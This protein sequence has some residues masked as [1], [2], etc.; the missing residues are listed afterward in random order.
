MDNEFIKLERD[1][2]IGIMYLNNGQKNY[3]PDPDFIDPLVIQNWVYD[4]KIKG[5][6]ITGMGKHFSA[7]ADI[8]R[9][10]NLARDNAQLLSKIQKGIDIL[11]AIE[12]LEIPVFAAITGACF[13]GGLEIALATHI[14]ISSN[15]SLFAFPETDLG[16]IPGLGG[17]L[18]L[19]HLTSPGKAAEIILSGRI[20]N[21]AQACELNIVDHVVP[22]NEV[23]AYTKSILQKMIEKK[24][25]EIINTVMRA[26][27]NAHTLNINDALEEES[28][29]FCRLAVKA[30]AKK[31]ID[32]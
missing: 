22:P 7:G 15:R 1:N 2:D 10:K 21:A 32:Q 11:N 13:G 25:L 6:I 4:S 14:R 16:L 5:L 26:V 29:M 3:I 20:I 12:N 23:I 24:P 9:L 30:M 27:H 17:T 31:N 8:D 28:R 18:R 19:V